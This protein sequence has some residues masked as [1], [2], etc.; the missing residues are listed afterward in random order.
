MTK[1]IIFQPATEQT[2]HLFDEPRPA[3][4]SVPSWYKKQKL[5]S[6]NESDL[7]KSFKK[8]PP[9]QGTYKLCVPLID[10]LTSGYIVKLPVSILVTNISIEKDKYIPFIKWNTV[11]FDPLDWITTEALAN[12]PI[13]NGYSS[14]CYRWN[15]DWITKTPKGYSLFIT[16]PSHRHD[17]PFFTINS[18][19]DTD[20]F[21]NKLFLPFFIKEGFEGIIEEGTPIAQILPFKRDNWKSE[22]AEYSEKIKFL[23]NNK[24]RVSFIR[25]YKEKVWSKKQ[26]L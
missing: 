4:N 9:G 26:Y 25:T 8:D 21:C 6:N 19:V 3:I 5:F 15:F 11:D 18:I 2:D 23:L 13:P 1:K 16:H 14:A 10:S 17:L 22:R 7:L 20:K 12:Y 24:M